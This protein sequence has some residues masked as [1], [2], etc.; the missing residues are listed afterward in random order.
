MSKNTK[1]TPGMK[2]PGCGKRLDTREECHVERIACPPCGQ[3]IINENQ[4]RLRESLLHKC[5]DCPKKCG[6]NS[7]RCRNC[8]Q[9]HVIETRP[10]ARKQ[11]NNRFA[12]DGG[13]RRVFDGLRG[14]G[15]EMPALLSGDG[16]LLRL[17]KGRG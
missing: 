16:G 15:G 12:V 7:T 3:A 14:D 11:L 1:F 13:T 5:A 17:R 8:A 9:K 4:R 6:R 2:C 10:E